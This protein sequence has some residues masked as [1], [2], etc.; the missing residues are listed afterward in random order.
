[1]EQTAL[2]IGR[3]PTGGTKLILVTAMMMILRNLPA[4]LLR[5]LLKMLTRC[6]KTTYLFETGT[7]C[8]PYL[9]K[10]RDLSILPHILHV[11]TPWWKLTLQHVATLFHQ[12]VDDFYQQLMCDSRTLPSLA[13]EEIGR[14]ILEYRKAIRQDLPFR[15]KRL[16]VWNVS[17]WTLTTRAGDAQNATH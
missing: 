12:G 2:R 8:P 17:G 10:I 7:Q 5:T 4:P 13:V 9:S 16:H 11:R 15:L 14:S 6:V 1:M 3:S